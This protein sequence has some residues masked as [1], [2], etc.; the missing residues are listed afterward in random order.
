MQSQILIILGSGFRVE[1][2]KK[3]IKPSKAPTLRGQ[4]FNPHPVNPTALNGISLIVSQDALK[5]HLWPE[6]EACRN[7]YTKPAKTGG[8]A[9]DWRCFP[10][11]FRLSDTRRHV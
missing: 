1:F 5:G 7:H 10:T 9:G 11:N 6:I 8:E 4:N 3:I 2:I